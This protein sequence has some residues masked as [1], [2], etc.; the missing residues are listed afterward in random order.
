MRKFV[1]C[2]AILI[3]AT[4][5]TTI[6]QPKASA[7]TAASFS[8]NYD[9]ESVGTALGYSPR[10]AYAAKDGENGVVSIGVPESGKYDNGRYLVRRTSDPGEKIIISL[11]FKLPGD[12]TGYSGV[13]LLESSYKDGKGSVADVGLTGR[14]IYTVGQKNAKLEDLRTDIKSNKWY[15]IFVVIDKSTGTWKLYSGNYASSETAFTYAEPVVDENQKDEYSA[16]LWPIGVRN[17]NKLAPLYIDNCE[18]SGIINE[19]LDVAVYAAKSIMLEAEIGYENGQ[20]PQSAVSMLK[21]AYDRIYPYSKDTTLS[22]E[23]ASAYATELTAAMKRFEKSKIDTTS[24]DGNAAYIVSEVADVLVVDSEQNLDKELTAKVYDRAKNEVSGDIQWE[25]DKE[26]SGVEVKNGR[27][28]VKVGTETEIELKASCGDIYVKQKVKL[29]V[30]KKVKE[31]S[32]SGENG[33]IIIKG[34]TDAKPDLPVKLSAVGTGINI[35]NE[36]LTVKDDN[37]FI[38]K[39][40]VP[41]DT[42][43]QNVTI[44]ISGDDM[45]GVLRWVKPYWGVGWEKSV[46]NDINN[47]TDET[48]LGSLLELYSEGLKMDTALYKN[49]SNVYK[50]RIFAKI[51]FKDLSEIISALKETEFIINLNEATRNEISEV[52]TEEAIDSLYR[53]GFDKNGF[54]NLTDTQKNGF[55]SNAALLETDKYTDTYATAAAKMNSV[56]ADITKPQETQEP[57][58]TTTTIITGYSGGGGGGSSKKNYDVNLVDKNKIAEKEEQDKKQ[59]LEESHDFADIDESMWAAEALSFMR[60]RGIMV[61]DGINVRPNDTVTRGEFSKILVT[62]F[63]L[64]GINTTAFSDSYEKWWSEYADIAAACGIMNGMGDGSFGGDTS[65]TREMLAVTIDRVLAVKGIELYEQ[66]ET[67]EFSDSD[68]AE[69]YAREAIQRL[70]KKGVI[71]GIGNNLFAPKLTVTRAEAAQIVYNVLKQ[72]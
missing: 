35:T 7:T 21:N 49:N 14:S 50:K 17:Y 51:T 5:I 38:Y 68:V 9:N 66:N 20:Y 37:T 40:S 48:S 43:F 46:L 42:P 29:T 60:K 45:N 59:N 26:Y 67:G 70:A 34:K 2:F 72:L 25:T 19:E 56:I 18:I 10:E 64:S 58:E 23:E 41:A 16:L 13:K 3:A 57:E 61:G 65:I 8:E 15:N 32:L 4:T 33:E 54:V 63:N 44:E 36:T 28:T 55:Y 6:V 1:R 69:K 53:V 71:S 62:S 27:L 11:D 47:A 12:V 52:L 39:G 31:I 22:P 30:G 24:S